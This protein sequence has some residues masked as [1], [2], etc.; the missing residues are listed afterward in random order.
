[1]S[2]AVRT[3]PEIVAAL[4]IED[5]QL[6]ATLYREDRQLVLECLQGTPAG[7]PV[8]GIVEELDFWTG[9]PRIAPSR[10]RKRV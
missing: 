5:R 2:G 7:T 10:R 9:L 8:A 3:I 1:M 4:T 6:L